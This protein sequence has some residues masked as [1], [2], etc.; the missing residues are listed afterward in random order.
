MRGRSS[1]KTGPPGTALAPWYA[2]GLKGVLRPTTY[3]P[4]PL[5]YL[6]TLELAQAV[7]RGAGAGPTPRRGG[8][9]TR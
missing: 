8:L 3:V 2:G 6:E 9:A 1:G 4:R 5:S 7:V